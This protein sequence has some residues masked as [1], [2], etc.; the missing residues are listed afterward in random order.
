MGEIENMVTLFSGGLWAARQW[1]KGNP[2]V[3]AKIDAMLQD[4]YREFGLKARILSII[5]GPMALLLLHREARRLAGGWKYEPPTFYTRNYELDASSRQ[6]NS[7][8]TLARWVAAD[9][10]KP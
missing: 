5:L 1:F 3:V 4:I 2:T 8:P 7:S 6:R 9:M 10:P